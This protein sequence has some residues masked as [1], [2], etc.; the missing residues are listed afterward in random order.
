[1][2]PKKNEV[3]N[4]RTLTEKHDN[5]SGDGVE[6]RRLL[7]FGQCGGGV[8]EESR[9]ACLHK[10]SKEE[11]PPHRTDEYPELVLAKGLRRWTHPVCGSAC[12]CVFVCAMPLA[13][14]QNLAIQNTQ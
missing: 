10:L 2:A 9:S 3:R 1:M 6:Q 5:A 11:D 12:V 13:R 7:V 4:G 14:A 8:E